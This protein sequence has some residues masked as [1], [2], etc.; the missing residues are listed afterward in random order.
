M[1]EE[2][3]SVGLDVHARSVSAAAIDGT[4]GELVKT[5]LSPGTEPIVAWLADLPGPVAVAYEAGPTGFGLARALTAAG[6]EC[7]VAAPSKIVRPAGDRIKT[8]ERDAVLLAR[9][10]R[11]G[12]LTP[13]RV[14]T[15]A[16]ESARDLVRAREDARGDLMR[17]RHR[18]SKLLLR[19][20]QVYTGGGAWTVK[21]EQ[22]LK[23]RHLD[24]VGTRAAFD[25]DF[26]TMIMTRDRRDRLEQKIGQLAADSEFTRA[27]CC[28]RGIS[29]L[30]GFALAVEIGDWQRFTGAS[31]GAYLGLVPGEHSSGSSRRLGPITK[32]GNNHAR[33]LLVEAAWHHKPLYR[34]GPTLRARWA[35]AT[36]AARTRAHAGNQRLHD[37]WVTLALRRK[38]HTVS[39]VAIARE[40]AGRCWSLAT[41]NL[42]TEPGTAAMTS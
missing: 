30:T 31:I 42:A 7:T 3:T 19:H 35:Q 6:M 38:T 10:L 26:E 27:L 9:L 34:P 33:R 15:P 13:V 2:R 18:I 17:V 36:P 37:R 5:R 12:E 24:G 32:T 23:A 21:H 28:L 1:G 29:T 40:L 4:T 22:W 25:A 11:M 41:L 14:P 16:Q 20:G 8:D 39:C